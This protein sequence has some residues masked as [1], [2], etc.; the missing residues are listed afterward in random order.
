MYVLSHTP[1]LIPLE[2]TPHLPL[3][4]LAEST[5]MPCGL[6]P[7]QPCRERPVS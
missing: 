4:P 1:E 7:L 2:F 3:N 5:P 6:D